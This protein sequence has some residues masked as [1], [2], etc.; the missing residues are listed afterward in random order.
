MNSFNEKTIGGIFDE[1][2]KKW[3]LKKALIY[4]GVR[5][6]FGE[7]QQKVNGLAKGLINLGVKPGDM[8]G[9]WMPNYPEWIYTNLANAKIGAVTVPINIRFKTRE[10]EYI[11][12]NS[13]ITTLLMSERFLTNHFAGMLYEMCPELH[14]AKPGNLQADSFPNLK[15]I[16]CLKEMPGMLRFDKLVEQGH[17]LKLD[18]ELRARQ[19]NILPDDVVNVFYTSGTTGLPKGAM[20]DHNVLLNIANYIKWLEI[21]EDDV[22]QIPSPLFYT[23]ANYWC[24]LC[25]IMAGAKMC[26]ATYFTLEEKLEQISKEKVTI[27]VGMAKM[28]VDMVNY[29][30]EHPYDTSSLRIG[31][32]GGGPITIEELKSIKMTIVEKIVNL[33][34]MTE[35]GGITTMTKIDDPLEILSSTIGTPLPNFE[36]KIMDP[37]T[38]ED[39]PQGQPGEL[40][41]KGPYVIKGYL[42]MSE[43]EK[44]IYFDKE[45]WYHTQDILIQHENGYYSFVGRI[46]DMIK[47]GGENVS[48]NEIDEFLRGHEKV[49]MACTIGV[50]DQVKQEVPL[51]FIEPVEGQIMVEDEILRY[52]KGKIA[53][54]KIPKHVRFT[55][56]WPTTATGK[57]QRFKLKELIESE[58]QS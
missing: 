5:I 49:K 17:G 10:V 6:T 56:D 33:Y 4:Q 16:I 24:M 9:I 45:G 44:A 1:S 29:L 43:E 52:C 32:T 8:V 15:N 39:L 57:I 7:L 51:A 50:P 36:L 22:F 35:T 42:N 30:K 14:D 54:Y 19:K 2:V 48:L 46:K 38:G 3:P 18:E 55:N 53:S 12:R 37:K 25:P 40:C 21:T 11:L 13:S 41:V 31:W 34:G 28:W 27:T 26:L 20:A 58:F 47:V 23:T